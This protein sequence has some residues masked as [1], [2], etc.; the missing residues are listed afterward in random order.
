MKALCPNCNTTLDLSALAEDA[1]SRAVFALIAQQPAVVQAQL[2][3][4]L[5]LFKPRLQGLRWSRAQ[6][7]LQTLVDATAD[8]SANR[9]AAAL[10]ET[11]NQ[12]AETRRHDSWKPL[13]SH[14]YLLRVI[15]STP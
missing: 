5:G 15:E 6:H 12:F 11:V 8:T 3:P 2:I 10:S 1:C 4:Y 7:L 13:N 9:L 14:N